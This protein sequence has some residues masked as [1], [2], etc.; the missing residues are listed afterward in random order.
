MLEITALVKSLV[1][2]IPHKLEKILGMTLTCSHYGGTHTLIKHLC[3]TLFIALALA[4]CFIT[5]SLIEYRAQV[6]LKCVA[7]KASSI[8]I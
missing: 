2:L 7:N 3:D 1:T 4:K 8:M 6:S 5:L